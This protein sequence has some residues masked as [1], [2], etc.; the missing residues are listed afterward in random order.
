MNKNK[1][2]NFSY[3]FSGI[4]NSKPET[5]G[6]AIEIGKFI[7]TKYPRQGVKNYIIS[8]FWLLPTMWMHSQTLRSRLWNFHLPK[9]TF[10]HFSE[11]ARRLF[12]S[13][14]KPTSTLTK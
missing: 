5:T 10:D 8:K 6:N 4:E 1:K 2:R 14:A 12:S 7:E 13:Y 11:I 9:Y 3:C